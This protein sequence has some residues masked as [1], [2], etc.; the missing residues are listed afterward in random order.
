[1]RK[2]G[3]AVILLGLLLLVVGCGKVT[4]SQKSS[5]STKTTEKTIDYAQLSDS[6][7]SEMTFTFVR[8]NDSSA[9]DLKIVNRTS[10][11]VTFN[12]DKFILIYPKKSQINS[13]K[14]STIKI[15]SNS[16]KTFKN[17]F[18]GLNS[19][20]FSTIGLYCYKNK[21]NKLAY[22]EINSLSA[23]STNLKES[24]LQ[25]A[26]KT[27]STKKKPVV[28]KKPKATNDTERQNSV[29]AGQITSGQQAVALVQSMNG[30]APQGTSYTFMT[31]ETSGTNGLVKT[32]DGQAVYWVRLFES[33]NGVAI[34]V[35]DWTV[36][37]N[38]TVI[39]QAPLAVGES[40][41]SQ[42]QDSDDNDSDDDNSVDS[43][44]QSDSDE[45]TDTNDDYDVDDID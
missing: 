13:T 37:P 21:N 41:N 5:Q 32:N 43:N 42:T 4:T 39:H 25:K 11:N 29:P 27:A 26:Y 40:K 14:D 38:R 17:L 9:V 15:G 6:E 45:N 24:S 16:T 7:Q 8:N 20:D 1:M 23:K 18:E 44:N 30:P 19:A 3:L 10:K 22:S 31:D 2:N 35:D 28:N 36:F 34:T 12:G 33:G